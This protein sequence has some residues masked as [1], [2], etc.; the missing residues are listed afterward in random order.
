MICTKEVEMSVITTLITKFCTVHAT[1]SLLSKR[2]PNGTVEHTEWEQSKIIRLERW[3]GAMSYCGLATCDDYGWSTY[4]WLNSQILSEDNIAT[5]EDFAKRLKDNLNHE[6]GKMKFDEP[7][8]AGIGIHLSV[9]EY[10]EERWIP[11]MFLLS[12]W[13]DPTYSTI[14]PK[15]VV[16]TRRTYRQMIEGRNH[17]TTNSLE[18]RLEVNRFLQDGYFLIFNNGDPLMFNTAADVILRALR[19]AIERKKTKDLSD[20]DVWL[21]IA[22]R[23]IEV[24]SEVQH[25]FYQEDSRIVGGTPHVLAVKPN[26]EYIST[27]G[28]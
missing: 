2:H 4:D 14:S 8:K 7:I 22:R 20:I 16:I 24:I 18:Q 15:G 1:D 28:D 26:G 23:P 9:Y 17:K 19:I 10:V 12:N 3:R 25:D 6:I 27:T 5:P 13:T 21:A 11:E